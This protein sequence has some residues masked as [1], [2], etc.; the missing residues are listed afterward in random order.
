MSGPAQ[1]LFV[2]LAV[3][4]SVGLAV[5]MVALRLVSITAGVGLLF[6]GQVAGALWW[7]AR[8]GR[9]SPAALHRLQTIRTA[10]V[11]SGA[12]QGLLTALMYGSWAMTA[13][14]E[15]LGGASIPL[16]TLAVGLAVLAGGAGSALIAAD[17]ARGWFPEP[18]AE[19]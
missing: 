19:P 13:S 1:R 3:T 7:F 6:G 15:A 17:I 8:M 18:E 4:Q 11:R 2:P 5:G 9:S 16:G 12:A 14:P 10:C